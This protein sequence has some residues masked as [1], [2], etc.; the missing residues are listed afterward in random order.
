M[1]NDKSCL[2]ISVEHLMDFI[3][4]KR[5]R[6]WAQKQN[7]LSTKKDSFENARVSYPQQ[8]ALRMSCE[9]NQNKNCYNGNEKLRIGILPIMS[10]TTSQLRDICTLQ[11]RCFIIQ[12]KKTDFSSSPFQFFWDHRLKRFDFCVGSV[13]VW[14]TFNKSFNFCTYQFFFVDIGK[15]KNI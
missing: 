4:K 10:S 13:R 15:E 11:A 6:K 2:N 14:Q 9:Q 7:S 1:E 8:T 5:S 12:R 3:K